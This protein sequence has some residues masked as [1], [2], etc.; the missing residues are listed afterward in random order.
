[1][2]L[3]DRQAAIDA[4]L[5]ITNCKSVRELFE[6]NQLHHLTEMWS[7]GVNDAIDAVIGVDSAQLGTNLAEVG[8]DCI[9]RQQAIDKFIDGLE[10]IFADLRE[11]HVDDSVCGLCE[12]DGA[13]VG[14]SGEWCNECPGFDRD[15]CFKLSDKTRK[16]W[17][18]EIIKALTPIQPD[19]NSEKPN[20]SDT[21]SSQA[22]IDALNEVVKD[23]SITDFDAIASILDLPPAQPEP[24]YDEWCTDCKE[25]D[26]E[27]SCCPRWTKVIRQTRREL[28]D[29]FVMTAVDGTLWVTVDDVQKVG[30]VIVDEEKSKFCRQFY[31]EEEQ[32][33][34]HWHITDAYPHNVYCSECHKRFAQTHW[35]VW[36][37]GS[38]P[39]NF[40][41][42]CGAKMEGDA[43]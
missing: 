26:H 33:T 5:H 38:L 20:N 18:E 28:Q 30:R 25:Y 13:Y 3:I 17:T 32:R 11:R 31:L 34:G 19:N 10:E 23:H 39:R 6:Y 35:A 43:E 15:D 29:E 24:H 41:P 21:I 40:C 7:G 14:Q 12:Y 27:N 37:D 1:M 8:T 42:N 9:S 22:A 16:E 2:E 4:I 36:E